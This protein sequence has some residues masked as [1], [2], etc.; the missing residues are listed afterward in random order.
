M[1][2]PTPLLSATVTGWVGG[3]LLYTRNK[4][5]SGQPRATLCFYTLAGK[6]GRPLLTSSELPRH[7]CD[8]P[9]PPAN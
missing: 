4:D 7:T 5:S 9:E 3:E 2:V 8:L 6:P 1:K